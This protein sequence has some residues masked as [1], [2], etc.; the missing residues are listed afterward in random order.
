MKSTLSRRSLG[1]G[2]A[3]LLSGIA[4]PAMAETHIVKMYTFDAAVSD[5]A[6][7]FDPP[8][9]QV[10]VGDTVKFEATQSGHNTAS[11]KGMIP[12]G[13]ESWNSP[14]DVDFEITFTADGTYGYIC[15]P[16][17]SVGMVGLVLVGDYK[18]NLDQARKVKHRGKAKKVFRALFKEVDAIE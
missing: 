9:I 2:L 18:T 11:K 16:H 8:L 10:A 4:A 15:S 13:A 17:Y 5:Q 7:F 6:D 14:M 3:L 12:E 1:L